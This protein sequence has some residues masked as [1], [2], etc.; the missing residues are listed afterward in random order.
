MNILATN[1]KT[2]EIIAFKPITL[3][4]QSTFSFKNIF[5]FILIVFFSYIGFEIIKKFVICIYNKY[6]NSQ[7]SNYNNKNG[8]SRNVSNEG[9]QRPGMN[10][11]MPSMKLGFSD[12]IKYT[13][14]SN[15]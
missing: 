13:N 3:E 6:T 15:G 12:K 1:Q 7:M 8:Y 9:Y 10:I 5:F 2:G 11:E 4:K 14:L